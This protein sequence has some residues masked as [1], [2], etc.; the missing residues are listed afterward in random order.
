LQAASRALPRNSSAQHAQ[1]LR[2]LAEFVVPAQVT[3][4][5]QR[6][7][8]SVEQLEILLLL[9]NKGDEWTPEQIS[10]ELR[11]TP[12]SAWNSV[13]ALQ[14]H[15]L[16]VPGAAP[17]SVRYAAKPAADATVAQVEAT[18][19]QARFRVIH[20]IFSKPSDRVTSFADAFRFRKKE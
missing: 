13:E 19:R 16:L 15:G 7:I 10:A 6:C 18:Y 17:G 9:R 14:R 3:E 8:E 20:L 11:S 2:P 4:F 1:E 12:D 5:V